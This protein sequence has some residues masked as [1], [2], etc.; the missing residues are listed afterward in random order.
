MIVYNTLRHLAHV[1]RE[2]FFHVLGEKVHFTIIPTG[3]DVIFSDEDIVH[4]PLVNKVKFL[5]ALL[6]TVGPLVDGTVLRSSKC[7]PVLAKCDG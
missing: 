7:A 4:R 5:Y 2:D 1:N 3:N 6:S